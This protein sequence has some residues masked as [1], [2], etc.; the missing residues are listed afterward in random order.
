MSIRV[1][2]FSVLNL[3]RLRDRGVCLGATFVWKRCF[4]LI[5]GAYSS[6]YN[7]MLWLGDI[8]RVLSFYCC[9]YTLLWMLFVHAFC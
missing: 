1:L 2:L 7:I 9:D 3:D 5:G 8:A 4:C 6:K